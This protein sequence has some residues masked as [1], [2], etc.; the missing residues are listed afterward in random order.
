MAH[1]M[2]VQCSGRKKGYTA[3]LMQVVVEHLKDR[4]DDLEIE[5]YHLH[6]YKI[7][8]CKSCFSCI[9]NVGSGC[10]IRDD[11]GK[12]GKGVL[13]RAFKRANGLLVVDPVHS[14]GISAIGRTF[15]ERIYPTFWEGVP[16]GLPFASISC[17]SNQGFQYRAVEEYCKLAAS[18]GF[19]YIGGLPVHAACYEEGKEQARELGERLAEAALEDERLG[20]R[21][22]TDEEIF[23]MYSGT[24]WDIID[25][26]LRNLTGNTLRYEDSIPLRALSSGRVDRP[27]AE[28]LLKR[29][30]EH[31][32]LALEYHH[33]GDREKTASE[34]A[35]AAKYWTHG[36]YKQYCEG[37]TVRTGIPG[38]YRPLDEK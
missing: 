26:Y 28:A 29:T 13:Y 15:F 12:K 36:T 37:I 4:Y 31:L 11:W 8:P 16:Y 24:P 27:E 7:K 23:L 38:T 33:S 21:K 20:R 14:W 9:R 22:L 35:L 10:T 3:T 1:L 25:G 17:A 32:K 2:V 30:C 18:H 19:R 5:V 6:D 34:L